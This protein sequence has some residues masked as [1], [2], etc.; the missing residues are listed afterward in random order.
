MGARK[1]IVKLEKKV[2]KLRT[3]LL[4]TRSDLNIELE[5]EM[6]RAN[7]AET[8]VRNLIDEL[9]TLK[10]KLAVLERTSTEK[11]NGNDNG[12]ES[13][14]TRIPVAEISTGTPSNNGSP[15]VPSS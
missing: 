1:K 8:K 9:D 15:T 2:R 7:I 3:K 13:A 10:L 5:K 11:P 6:Y 12:T 14:T 4:I